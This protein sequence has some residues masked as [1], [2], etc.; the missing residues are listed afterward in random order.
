MFTRFIGT[1]GIISVNVTSAEQ[2]NAIEI[3]ADYSRRFVTG[4]ILLSLVSINA[5][6]TYNSF[7]LALSRNDSQNTYTQLFL[8]GQVAAGRYDVIFYDINRNRTVSNGLVYP[9]VDRGELNIS[10]DSTG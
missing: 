1:H 9:A 7:L 2:S 6:S 10:G 8:G 5:N 3:A 4:G